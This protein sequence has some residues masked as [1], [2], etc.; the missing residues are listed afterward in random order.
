MFFPCFSHFVHSHFFWFSFHS[1]PQGTIMFCFVYCLNIAWILDSCIMCVAKK[2]R[3]SQWQ[4]SSVL[5][6]FCL[7][8]RS[9]C[10][11]V[12]FTCDYHNQVFFQLYSWM[13]KNIAQ[14]F[15]FMDAYFAFGFFAI[16]EEKL[17][18]SLSLSFWEL[19]LKSTCSWEKVFF[20]IYNLV[21]FS[22]SHPFKS[23]SNNENSSIQNR[24]E[25]LEFL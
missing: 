13:Y 12:R 15:Q 22:V 3:K 1:I 7:F 21:W 10:L 6:V 25:F 11:F 4:S 14:F 8:V 20:P 19:D 17:F 9:V 23:N 5:S 24:E 18:I 2:K 16:H